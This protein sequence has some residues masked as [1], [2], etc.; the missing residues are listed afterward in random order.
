MNE[1]KWLIENVP[2]AAALIIMT[3]MWLS[4]LKSSDEGA[5]ETFKTI[6]HES[7]NRDEKCQG[8]IKDNT[9][10]LG[11]VKQV[12][13]GSNKVMAANTEAL[14]KVKQTFKEHT[15]TINSLKQTIETK[16]P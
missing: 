3:K 10:V 16:I 1:F 11:Q 4:H 2:V 8:V 13:E 15:V 5:R 6:A 7:A 14:V 9:D 12:M